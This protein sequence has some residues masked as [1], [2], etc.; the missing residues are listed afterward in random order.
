MPLSTLMPVI[1]VLLWNVVGLHVVVL[2]LTESSLWWALCSLGV[3][4][5]LIVASWFPWDV[6][7][8]R[9]PSRLSQAPMESE[10]L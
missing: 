9:R 3:V 2:L 7:I 5:A 8:A 4:T 1:Y 6:Y 10:Q